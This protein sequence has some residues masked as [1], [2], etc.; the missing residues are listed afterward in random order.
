MQDRSPP[1]CQN[2]LAPHGRTIHVGHKRK[3]SKRAYVVRFA[4]NSDQIA[5]I[6]VGPL[7][8]DFVAEVA[9]ERRKLRPSFE[10][11]LWL[12]LAPLE[13]VALKGYADDCQRDYLM[14]TPQLGLP[15]VAAGRRAWP[16]CG[17]FARSPPA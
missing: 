8:A 17:G 12:P 3:S 7:C 9:D 1:A 5:D 15:A 11:R 4:P 16:A 10:P 14:L 6:P 2:L 13:A